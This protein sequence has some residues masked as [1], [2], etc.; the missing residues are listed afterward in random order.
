MQKIPQNTTTKNL[1]PCIYGDPSKR[2]FRSLSHNY[3]EN[4]NSENSCREK[5][6][7]NLPTAHLCKKYS[8]QNVQAKVEGGKDKDPTM[9]QKP[10]VVVQTRR[11]LSRP[12]ID[13][14]IDQNK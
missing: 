2:N 4:I 7:Q 12:W 9:D 5:Q 14:E 8:V 13:K 6:A 11:K 10:N 3:K 1:L